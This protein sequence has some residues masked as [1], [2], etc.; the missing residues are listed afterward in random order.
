VPSRLR[1]K[2]DSLVLPVGIPQNLMDLSRH[3]DG[4][5]KWKELLIQT[6][7]N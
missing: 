4:Q 2:I 5:K 3:L 1:D 7:V 6:R